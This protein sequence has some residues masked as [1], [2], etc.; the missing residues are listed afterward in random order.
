M[1]EAVVHR[2][3]VFPL[4][5]PMRQR[6]CHAAAR[7]GVAESVVVGLELTDGTM[8]FGETVAQSYV[9]GESAGSVVS[10]I[11]DILSPAVMEFHALSFPE[12]LEAI[13]ALPWKDATGHSIPAARAAVELA[14]LDASLRTFHRTCDDVVQ[15]LELPRFGTPGSA[16][17][18]RISH[19][20]AADSTPATL[21]QL[22]RMY[23]R[24]LRR[25]TLKVGLEGDHVRLRKVAAYLAK[26][27]AKKTAFLRIDADGGWSARE[28]EAWLQ[29]HTRAFVAAVEQ[30]IARGDDDSLALL[31]ERVDL[32]IFLDESVI[33]VDDAR[34]AIE[35][36][37]ADGI[38]L[39]LSKCGGF[40][41]TLRMASL[42]LRAGLRLKVDHPP[43]CTSI[44]AAATVRF[45]EV[46]PS[47]EWVEGCAVPL[48]LRSDVVH[49]SVYFGYGGRV[50]RLRAPGLGA[51]VNADSLPGLCGD[52]P[53][54]LNL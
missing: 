4:T 28:A 11:Q 30:P 23:W 54:I 13:D 31:R 53:I 52:S 1:P 29:E 19:V 7:L 40:L 46:C 27:L 18:V 36:G 5:L 26:P 2:I 14:L 15:W 49:Q 39:G 45:L 48:V 33:T 20:L 37:V 22:R 41:P 10:T 12:A 42:T 17:A 32:P 34:R 6:I 38:S 35:C 47:V 25:F 43:T 21:K 44:L 9:T 50:P 16:T 3:S 8:G 51:E 24:G